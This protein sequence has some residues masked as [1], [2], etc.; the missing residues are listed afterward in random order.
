[1]HKSEA[2]SGRRLAL[3]QVALVQVTL[4][5]AAGCSTAQ[6]PTRPV[7]RPATASPDAGR[8]TVLRQPATPPLGWAGRNDF[9]Y[10]KAVLPTTGA[11][12]LSV[13]RLTELRGPAAAAWVAQHPQDAS[14]NDLP[15]IA[16]Q[17]GPWRICLPFAARPTIRL[18]IDPQD[19]KGN[20][21]HTATLGQ[22]QGLLADPLAYGSGAP[23]WF[24]TVAFYH[25]HYDKAGN[26]DQVTS[27]WTP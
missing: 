2:R 4:A 14:N 5:T 24:V 21:L 6:T 18:S 12:C 19:G 16:D 22:L 26:V 11:P 25:W 20:R 3:V 7:V 1:M 10:A 9:G 15:V 27:F 13:D 23:T 17:D 8:A